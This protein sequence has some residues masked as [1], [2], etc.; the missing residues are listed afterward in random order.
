[1]PIGIYQRNKEHKRKITEFMYYIIPFRD[2]L[3]EEKIED[4]GDFEENSKLFDLYNR[5]TYFRECHSFLDS[6]KGIFQKVM[7]K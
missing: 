5:I 1:M 4:I 3:K 6:Y 2:I 7:E